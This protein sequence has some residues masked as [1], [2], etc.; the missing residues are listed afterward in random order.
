MLKN[1]NYGSLPDWIMAFTA[2]VSLRQ[3]WGPLKFLLKI[4][5]TMNQDRNG[6]LTVSFS[7]VN[8]S[9]VAVPI[10][11]DGIRNETDC[12]NNYSVLT[13]MKSTDFNLVKSH[14]VSKQYTF[15]EQQLKELLH[16]PNANDRIEICFQTGSGKYISKKIRLI[17]EINKFREK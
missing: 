8:N 10:S 11:F 7:I 1:I 9:K 14:E 6:E 2:I 15:T 16:N 13:S 5:I 3:Y 17:K 4:L 12:Q